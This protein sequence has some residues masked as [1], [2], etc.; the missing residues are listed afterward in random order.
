[1]ADRV[2]VS[3]LVSDIKQKPRYRCRGRFREA[4]RERAGWGV[5]PASM[6]L[7]GE[8]SAGL[9]LCIVSGA[10]RGQSAVEGVLTGQRS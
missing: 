2:L 6:A 5:F 8:L 7:A 1:M 3:L 9:I 4:G 10:V